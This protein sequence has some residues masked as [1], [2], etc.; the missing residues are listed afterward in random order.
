MNRPHPKHFSCLTDFL[1][2]VGRFDRGESAPAIYAGYQEGFEDVGGFDCY[3]LTADIPGHPQGSTVSAETLT[4]LGYHVPT[5]T[6][7]HLVSPRPT[8]E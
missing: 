8:K 7:P 5:K 3:H 6:A 2:A 4:Q 1:G